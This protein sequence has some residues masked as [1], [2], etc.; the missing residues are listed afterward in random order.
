MALFAM[1]QA[2]QRGG[3]MLALAVTGA[4]GIVAH[5]IWDWRRKREVA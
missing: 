3:L 5:L 4:V 1:D 2:A